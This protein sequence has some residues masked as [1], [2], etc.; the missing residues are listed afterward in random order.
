MPTVRHSK[1]SDDFNENPDP[2]FFSQKRLLLYRDIHRLHEAGYSMRGISRKLKCSRNTVIKYLNGEM[3]NICTPTLFSGVDWY[4]DYIIKSLSKGVC[5]SDIIRGMREQ[6]LICSNT[7][8]YY[9]MNKL[10]AYYGIELIPIQDCSPEQK[11]KRKEILKYSYVSRKK[12]FRF[13]WMGEGLNDAQRTWIFDKYPVV[14]VLYTCIRE[15]REIF[16]E[17]RQSLMVGFIKKYRSSGIKLLERLAKSFEKD[18]DAI[19]NAVSSRLSNGFV[20]GTNS[21][22]KM[23]K[24]TMYGRCGMKLLAAKLMLRV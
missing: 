18:I 22:L 9:Y 10:A 24:R 16:R 8:A 7:A 19:L 21:K 6:G 3:E 1:K 5:R 2:D 13:L 23:I 12:V 20:E 15:F 11:A 17:G 14:F 4:R